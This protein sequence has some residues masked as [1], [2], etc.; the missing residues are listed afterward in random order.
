MEAEGQGGT[1][2]ISPSHAL[3]C[4]LEAGE[5]SGDHPK[6]ERGVPHPGPLGPTP[7]GSL[8]AVW[9]I[10]EPPP[11]NGSTSQ[12]PLFVPPFRSILSPPSC[13]H[14]SQEDA[15][16]LIPETGDLSSHPR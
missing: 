10:S 11:R 7:K 9:D 8:W 15:D 13:L 16:E 5:E 2:A 3:H 14:R 4:L 1:L 6:E 12:D